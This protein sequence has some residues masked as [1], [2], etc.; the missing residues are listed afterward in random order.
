[1]DSD[2]RS[3]SPGPVRLRVRVGL[4]DSDS[5]GIRPSHGVG[6]DINPSP[7]RAPG[8]AREHEDGRARASVHPS[9]ALGPSGAC[10]AACRRGRG[11]GPACGRRRSPWTASLDGLLGRSPWPPKFLPGS[12]DGLLGHVPIREARAARGPAC[13][14]AR[15]SRG[16]G[17]PGREAARRPSSSS[18]GCL[19]GRLSRRLLLGSKA[20]DLGGLLGS[21]AVSLGLRRSPWI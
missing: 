16:G 2:C 6:S 21:K 17:R 11:P 20:V 5:R 15:P 13:L 8:R 18:C 10:P 9:A 1:M 19:S 7:T 12:L 14:P 4:H 3:G